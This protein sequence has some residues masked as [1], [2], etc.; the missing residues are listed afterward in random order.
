MNGETKSQ[1][2]AGIKSDVK[3]EEKSESQILRFEDLPEPV[4][5]KLTLREVTWDEARLR[6]ACGSFYNRVGKRIID[7]ILSLILIVPL[8]PVYALL[9]LLV[10]LDSGAPVWYRAPRGGYRG[11]TFQ[12][13]KYRTMVQGAD[14]LGGT[15]A[16]NDQRI[17]R[18]GQ[19]L[20]HSKLDELPQFFNVL[21][22]DMS[23][24][25]PRP[26]L[27]EY[28]R[29]YT[30]LE[31]YI[32]QVRP[33]ITDWS[34]LTFISLDEVVGSRNADEVYERYVLPRKNQLRLEYVAGLSLKEDARIFVRT[35]ADVL[36]KLI[37]RKSTH[38]GK[39]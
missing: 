36:K 1:R 27:L 35:L 2:T 39:A 22:G 33:G 7:I 5:E 18:I 23:F 20:R 31:K 3:S 11:K 6:R 9:S 8:L 21:L 34:S 24:I 16:L 30:G 32:L 28:T 19:V 37:H 15:T 13:N 25:G 29:R 10:L 38:G 17:T 12:I 14:R 26:E 4:Q